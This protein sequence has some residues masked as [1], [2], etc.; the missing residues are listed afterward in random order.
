MPETVPPETHHADPTTT[1]WHTGYQRALRE[2]GDQ[3]LTVLQARAA[4]AREEAHAR[5]LA[6]SQALGETSALSALI[7]QAHA[8]AVA[9]SDG[10]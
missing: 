9:V 1:A 3:P 7:D 2:H 10:G 6:Y 4:A 8:A 5:G